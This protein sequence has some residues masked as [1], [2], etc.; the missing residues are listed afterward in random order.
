[1]K[2]LAEVKSHTVAV[3]NT[4]NLWELETITEKDGT[5]KEVMKSFLVQLH[6]YIKMK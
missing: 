6:N 2:K 1:M 3:N 4:S 5:K